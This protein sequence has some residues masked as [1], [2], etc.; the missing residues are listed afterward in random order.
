MEEVGS[1]KKYYSLELLT[2]WI[3]VVRGVHSSISVN[4]PKYTTIDQIPSN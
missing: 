4:L 1:S 2:Y 3:L